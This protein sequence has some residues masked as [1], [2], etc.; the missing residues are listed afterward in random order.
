VR[1]GAT[2]KEISALEVVSEM[3]RLKSEVPNKELERID[4]YRERLAA[5]LASLKEKIQKG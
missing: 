3:V 1:C 2:V 5:G 4:D